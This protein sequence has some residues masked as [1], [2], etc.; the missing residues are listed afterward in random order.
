MFRFRARIVTVDIENDRLTNRCCGGLDNCPNRLDIASAPTESTT[1][2][3][4]INSNTNPDTMA[5]D[6]VFTIDAQGISNAQKR[7][8]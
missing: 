3:G 8:E 1:L 6:R 4:V 7:L 5:I 2:I